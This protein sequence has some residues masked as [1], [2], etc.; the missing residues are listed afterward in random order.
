MKRRVLSRYSILKGIT[1]S[2]KTV[3]KDQ[4]NI[5]GARIGENT[6]I[7][8]FVYIEEGVEIGDHV[9]IRPFTF[10]PTGVRI[11]DDV[12][13]GPGVMFTNDKY[14]R[15]RGKWRL[16]KTILR[17]GCA[18]GAGAV[19]LPGVNIGEHSLVGGGSVVSR[20]VPPYAI[21]VGNPARIVGYLSDSNIKE[22]IKI[23]LEKNPL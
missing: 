19:I 9:K 16:L 23:L 6:K 1:V 11:E 18:I 20:D 2:P 21:V 10:I 5:Y 4:V 14:P 15:A 12:L 3:I 7:D 22:K 8:A 17:K 13:V